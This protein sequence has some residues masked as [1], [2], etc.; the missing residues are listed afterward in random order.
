MNEIIIIIIIIII[1]YTKPMLKQMFKILDFRLSPCT[2]YSKLS[3][4]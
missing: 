1:L 4:G 3:I 2:E